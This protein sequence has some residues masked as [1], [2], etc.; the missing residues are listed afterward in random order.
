MGHDFFATIGRAR[1]RVSLR[2]A[3]LVAPS[4]ALCCL[5]LAACNGMDQTWAT[6]APEQEVEQEDPPQTPA[7]PPPE[8]VEPGSDEPGP[9]GVTPV[10]D[11]EEEPV[12]PPV[13]DAGTDPDP[14]DPDPVDP[15]DPDPVDPD[16]P[17]V[18]F[19]CSTVPAAPVTFEELPGFT[20]AEDFAF[21]E[22]GNYIGVDD[23]ANLVRISKTGEK[24]LWLPSVGATAGM[25]ILPDGSVVICDVGE[26]AL[27]RVYPNGAVSVVLGGLLYPNGL[28]IGPDG[29][30]YVAENAGGRVRRVNPDTGEFT[31]V[32]LGLHGPNGVAFTNDPSLLY[33]GSFEGSGVYKLE[34]PAPGE[35]G[36]ASV[37]ARPNGSTLREPIIA[38]P[39]NQ[40]GAECETEWYGTGRC[41]A[42]A[43]VVDCLPVDPCP[44]L[45]DGT[46]CSYPEY[47]TC[48]EGVCVELP[49]PCD[50]L[51]EGDACVDS[52]GTEGVCQASFGELYCGPPNP[53]DGLEAG[54]A[55]EDPFFGT[56]VC[57]T[58]SG[59]TYCAFPDPCEGR[60]DG[61][62][63]ED[64]FSGAG[65]C[66]SDGEY[67][68]CSPINPCE[69]A[70]AGAVCE[71]PFFGTGECKVEDGYAYC[72]PPNA[73]E[74]LEEGAFCSD[75]YTPEG[76][77]VAF[78]EELS[79][80]PPNV[81]DDLVLGDACDDFGFPGICVDYDGHLYCGYPDACDTL[82]EG[83]ACS[84]EFIENG[85]CSDESGRLLCTPPNPCD[86]LSAGAECTDSY[87]GVGV[88]VCSGDDEA[89]SCLSVACVGLEDGA[90][91]N[92]ALLGVG[93]CYSGVC[94]GGPSG[95]GGIDGMGVDTC[96]NVYATEYTN[97]NVWRISPAGDIELL[98][99]LPSGWIPNVKWGRDLGGF[100]SQVMYVADRDQGRLFGISVGVPG[101]TEFF[102]SQP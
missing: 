64:P 73:C 33:I 1:Y 98:V 57:E 25:G 94:Y 43:N 88:G 74:G 7:D 38:C 77:C 28:D 9:T 62:A 44:E 53:C 97:G 6:P 99:D 32:A 86:G 8:T 23:N 100:S 61:D 58:D 79:C 71:D 12:T 80:T 42:I 91:C 69:G 60:A 34:L 48:Q 36:H 46:E 2:T 19:D 10:V 75:V 55:C 26:G 27:K 11:K 24:Q 76:R 16:P 15:V 70:E 22:L 93:V 92:D 3:Q 63:C 52:V 4:T 82:A 101:A 72:N 68:Y 90:R 29:F 21:D 51:A 50:G 87:V 17:I 89:L 37:F 47:G 31:I 18:A 59:Y 95:P 49:N 56:G 13:A 65:E 35:L 78:E 41:Q 84:N 67:M 85:V 45:P 96:G 30:I 5:I 66:V 54:A 39:D 14:P 83:D 40:E 81:C 20:S 102:A